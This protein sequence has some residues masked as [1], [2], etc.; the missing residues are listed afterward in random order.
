[1]YDKG[2]DALAIRVDGKRGSVGS[3]GVNG[4]GGGA[5]G[6][7]VADEGR[8]EGGVGGNAGGVARHGDTGML[9]LDK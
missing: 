3:I 1:M 7:G 9:L 4:N 8:G 6:V 5:G 2:F